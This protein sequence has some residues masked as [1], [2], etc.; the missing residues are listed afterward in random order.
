MWLEDDGVAADC[1]L[2]GGAAGV[3]T[4]LA[5]RPEVVRFMAEARA[6]VPE[7]SAEMSRW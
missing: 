1:E 2:L 5:A 7:P 6:A 3:L 4:A